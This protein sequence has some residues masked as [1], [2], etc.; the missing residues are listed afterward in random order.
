MIETTINVWDIYDIV[1]L[2]VTRTVVANAE[3]VRQIAEARVTPALAG[4]VRETD[5]QHIEYL[6]RLL[7][8]GIVPD[9]WVLPT[10]VRELR[11]LIS[12]RDRLVNTGMRN[13]NRLHSLIHR[14]NLLLGE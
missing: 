5:K 14:H 2:L 12:Y 11:G 10:H 6:I 3:A 13:R 4:G 8:A 7:V 1:A 9:V